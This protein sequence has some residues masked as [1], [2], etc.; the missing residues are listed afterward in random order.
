VGSWGRETNRSGRGHVTYSEPGLQGIAGSARLGGTL[1]AG[2]QTLQAL[3]SWLGLMGIPSG[4]VLVV[5]CVLQGRLRERNQQ[6]LKSEK[7]SNQRR[8]WRGSG[9]LGGRIARQEQLLRRNCH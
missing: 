3:R 9:E 1:A 6:L 4:G 8:E 7:G 2:R 5:V